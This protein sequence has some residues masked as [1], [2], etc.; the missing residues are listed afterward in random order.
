M[1]IV[2]RRRDLTPAE[3]PHLPRDLSDAAVLADRLRDAGYPAAAVSGC[4]NWSIDKA[5]G[6]PDRTG[7]ATRS[8]Y[9]KMLAALSTAPP[10]K[11]RAAGKV[12]PLAA[13][14]K[15][16]ANGNS[17]G[18]PRGAAA[19][20]NRA[21]PSATSSLLLMG[22]LGALYITANSGDAPEFA[23]PGVHEHVY[24]TPLAA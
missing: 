9:R 15:P 23:L 3:A 18:G 1:L 8:R 17:S 22:S 10:P 19:K 12:V 21:P 6:R 24:D 16:A 5:L 13:E 20:A 14:V 2:P 7:P 4:V 11:L